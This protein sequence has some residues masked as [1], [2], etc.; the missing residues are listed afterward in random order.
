MFGEHRIITRTVTI[1][2]VETWTITIGSEVVTIT[3]EPD[4]SADTPIAPIADRD[5]ENYREDT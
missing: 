3:P 5:D 4:G 2:T 1:T